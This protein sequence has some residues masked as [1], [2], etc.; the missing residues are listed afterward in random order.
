MPTHVCLSEDVY[1]YGDYYSDDSEQETEPPQPNLSA[2][3]FKEKTLKPVEKT[4]EPKEKTLEPKETIGPT[5]RTTSPEEHRRGRQQQEHRRGR[6]SLSL[7]P[8]DPGHLTVGP[9]RSA[10]RAI[11]SPPV[12]SAFN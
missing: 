1:A 6:L 12:L 11:M 7:S 10:E 4:L 8:C 9:L 3:T 2:K 5:G